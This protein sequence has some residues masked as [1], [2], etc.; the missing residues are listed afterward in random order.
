[1]NTEPAITPT[2][3]KPRLI[4]GEPEFRPVSVMSNEEKTEAVM[5]LL[6]GDEEPVNETVAYL[7]EKLKA[8]MEEGPALQKELQQMAERTHELRSRLA[9]IGANV[10]AYRDDIVEWQHRRPSSE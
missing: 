8:L 6:Q 1:M 5:R 10:K 3:G 7:A 9:D 2:N 4:P